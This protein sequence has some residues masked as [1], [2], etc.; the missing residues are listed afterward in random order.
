MTY[1][2]EQHSTVVTVVSFN[3]PFHSWKQTM[4]NMQQRRIGQRIQSKQEHRSAGG[5]ITIL[6]QVGELVRSFRDS[7]L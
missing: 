6:E 4:V 3:S 5:W 7:G 1:A 2:A